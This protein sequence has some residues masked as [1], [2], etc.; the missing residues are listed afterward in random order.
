VI[1][2]IDGDILCYR[3]GFATQEE[4]QDVAIRTMASF[5]EELVMFE[6]NVSEWNT[7]L[8]GPT[9]FRNDFIVWQRAVHPYNLGWLK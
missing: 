2:L 8:T 4:S 3:I 1:A 9:N 6:L 5:L 7:Y